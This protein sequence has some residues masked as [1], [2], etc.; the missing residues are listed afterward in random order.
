MAPAKNTEKSK[1]E[2]KL[3]G[4]RGNIWSFLFEFLVRLGWTIKFLL[5]EISGVM[6]FA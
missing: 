3:E 6:L 2:E 5:F 4:E 1:V